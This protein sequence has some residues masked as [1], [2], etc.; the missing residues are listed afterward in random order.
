DTFVL[1]HLIQE[2]SDLRVGVGEVAVVGERHLL[3]FDLAHGPLG[4]AVLTRLALLGRDDVVTKP[5]DYAL[6]AALVRPEMA[7]ACG[8]STSGNRLQL[9]R[10][11]GVALPHNAGAS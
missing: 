2:A 7:S 4:V 11:V 6:H 1:A 5:R 9:D 10:A 3:L 8:Y